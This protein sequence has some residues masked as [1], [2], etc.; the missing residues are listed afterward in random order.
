MKNMYDIQQLLIKYGTI[1]YTGNRSSD[2]HLMEI[3]I[4]EL[5]KAHILSSKQYAQIKGVLKKELIRAK[6]N[7]K[8][9]S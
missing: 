9:E 1:I 6:N 8:D 3:E 4:D 5:Y 2:L 7:K